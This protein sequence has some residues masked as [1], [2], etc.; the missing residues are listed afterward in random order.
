MSDQSIV[1]DVVESPAPEAPAARPV[2]DALSSS[3]LPVDSIVAS[4]A[5]GDPSDRTSGGGSSLQL[6]AVGDATPMPAEASGGSNKAAVSKWVQLDVGDAQGTSVHATAMQGVEGSGGSLPHRG[7]IQ[8]HFGHHDVSGVQSYQGSSAAA[9][10]S[11]LGAKAYATDNKV[12][13]ASGSASLH[14]AAHEAAHVIQQKQGVQLKGGVG[15][16]GDVYERHADAVADA[17]V[18]GDSA[19]GLLDRVTGT[20]TGD[21]GGTSS[22]VQMVT[23]GASSAAMTSSTADVVSGGDEQDLEDVEEDD[24]ARGSAVWSAGKNNIGIKNETQVTTS[25]RVGRGAS[26]FLKGF[27]K[28]LAVFPHIYDWIKEVGSLRKS[29]GEESA[30]TLELDRLYGEIGDG[31]RYWDMAK[32]SVQMVANVSTAVSVVFGIA[33][34]FMPALAPVATVAG[35]VATVAHALAGLMRIPTLVAVQSSLNKLRK[36]SGNA[37]D[38]VALKNYRRKDL[39]GLVIN[40]IGVLFGG[41]SGSLTQLAQGNISAGTNLLTSGP[42]M[43][44]HSAGVNNAIA[45][46]MGEVGNRTQDVIGGGTSDDNPIKDDLA[47]LSEMRQEYRKSKPSVSGTRAKIAPVL[48]QVSAEVAANAKQSKAVQT[49]KSSVASLRGSMGGLG[50]AVES[51]LTKRGDMQ[52]QGDSVVSASVDSSVQDTQAPGG[53]LDA[54]ASRID[55]AQPGAQA[56][57]SKQVKQSK[58][59]KPS[60][61]MK[62]AQSKQQS[63]AE[64]LTKNKKIDIDQVRETATSGQEVL[65]QEEAGLEQAETGM[66]EWANKLADIEARLMKI[67]AKLTEIEGRLKALDAELAKIQ[68]DLK[69]R[70]G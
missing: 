52:S 23:D 70:M 4:S 57:F 25:Q 56:L 41:L 48:K 13:F 43:A 26:E 3:A 44:N 37:G 60:W 11:S 67:D 28:N 40:S 46:G 39:G 2:R 64:E 34:V 12:A 30:T 21:A 8:E 22:S 54:A 63:M 7:V 55:M 59:K 66:Q 45:L 24:S 14:T 5:A 10:T 65:Q 29:S 61:T 49:R 9:A 35:I 1:V 33:S 62:L 17:V 53:A 51:V 16:S 19:E 18:R 38:A 27:A 15:A 31:F 47:R 69:S 36:D 20:S 50:D 32:S 42:N 58:E 68:K 6:K